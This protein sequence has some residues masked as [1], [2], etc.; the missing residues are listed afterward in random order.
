MSEFP[1]QLFPIS[2]SGNP[3]FESGISTGISGSRG[4]DIVSPNLCNQ[5]SWYQQA[6]QVVPASP[7]TLVLD[8]GN[9]YKDSNDTTVWINP[10]LIT[11]Q[12]NRILMADGS[13]KKRIDFKPIFKE[14]GSVIADS[15]VSSID[16]LNAKVTFTY[17]PTGTIT[18]E[19]WKVS[20]EDRFKFIVSPPSGKK[21]FIS[22]SE[23]QFSLDANMGSKNQVFRFEVL[24]GAF[25]AV[26]FKD[27]PL[28]L[29]LYSD[30]N[31]NQFAF[32]PTEPDP[33]KKHMG[34]RQDYFRPED[35]EGI[36]NVGKNLVPDW[37]GK[38]YQSVEF[39]FNYL[40]GIPLDF[41]VASGCRV[42]CLDTGDI[43]KG[44]LAGSY[45]TF[46]LYTIF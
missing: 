9:T 39:P 35:F 24:I 44:A 16:Y 38:G 29:G 12:E 27:I 32:H 5:S 22:N 31:Y 11:S 23:I 19:G 4:V 25:G 28:D 2:S 21:I 43:S 14:K 45:A 10:T 26:A 36:S 33:F 37:G 30:T 34:A 17:A 6:V 20:T 46:T 42:Y 13:F 18:F 7:D 3:I 8:T 1:L 15:S 41:S 40:Q